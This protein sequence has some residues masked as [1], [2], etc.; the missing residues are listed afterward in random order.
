MGVTV[1]MA[2]CVSAKAVLT[3]DMAVS[4]LSAGLSVGV[5]R[6]LLQDPSIAARNKGMNI[7]PKMFTFQLP[8][9]FC[10]EAPN[11]VRPSPHASRRPSLEGKGFPSR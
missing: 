9:M 2:L 10:K 7:L 11:G 5:D 4:I 8:L 1:G 6:K 3:V